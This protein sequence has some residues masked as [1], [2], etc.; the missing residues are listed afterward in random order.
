MQNEVKRNFILQQG[1]EEPGA[2]QCP[3]QYSALQ[4]QPRTVFVWIVVGVLLQSPT[5]FYLLCAVLWW[6]ALLPKF[7]PFDVLYNLI[8]GD[9]QG[10][11]SHLTPAP[12]PRRTAQAMA[13]LFAL[14]SG[15]FIEFG[16]STSA[17][18]V[19]GIFLAAVL[20]LILG[21][22][23]LGS[24]VFHLLSGKG[25]FACQTLPWATRGR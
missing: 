3:R 21:G 14:S 2:E 12:A 10:G 24:F 9:H 19:E 15:L 18:V 16:H 23:C 20:A 4:F 22:F 13:G 11:A 8:F 17:Y 6:S 7:N 1:F 25:S 5:V